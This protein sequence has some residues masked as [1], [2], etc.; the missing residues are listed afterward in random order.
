MRGDRPRTGGTYLRFLA[1]ASALAAAV[2]LVG[3]LPT[4]RLGGPGAVSAMLAG[5]AVSLIASA[6]GGVPIALARGGSGQARL[7]AVLL[8]MAVRLAVELALVLAAALSGLFPR[9]PLLVWA[10]LSYLVLLAADTGFALKAGEG[11]ETEKR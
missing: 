9:G 6:C 10:A 5:C 11:L 3:L 1:M 8:S 7:Q 2:A 4:R